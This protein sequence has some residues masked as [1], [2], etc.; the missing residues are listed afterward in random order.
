M[1]LWLRPWLRVGPVIAIAGGLLWLLTEGDV[2][3]GA[4]VRSA[5][6]ALVVWVACGLIW[7]GLDYCEWDEE[8][9]G[10]GAARQ[11]ARREI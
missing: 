2:G 4:L 8:K 11:P 9:T 3:A 7:I 5:V 6:W 1:R 10:A